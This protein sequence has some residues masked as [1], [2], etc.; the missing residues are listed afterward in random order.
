MCGDAS[1]NSHMKGPGIYFAYF[2]QALQF[3]TVYVIWRLLNILLH[4][5]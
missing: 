3:P 5:S 1:Y 4:G 2:L